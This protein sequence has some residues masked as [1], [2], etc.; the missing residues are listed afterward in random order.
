MSQRRRKPNSRS[1]D[2]SSFSYQRR[3]TDDPEYRNVVR[4]NA[5]NLIW[6]YVGAKTLARALQALPEKAT[7]WPKETEF[8]DRVAEFCEGSLKDDAAAVRPILENLL[9]DT[10]W[11]ARVYA[12]ECMIILYDD[13][14]ASLEP[15]KTDDTP[16]K[17]WLASGD[18]TIG[19]YVSSLDEQ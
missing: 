6:N 17:G 19:N 12:M 4:S 13:A 11:V 1:V 7:W 9:Y 15:L 14:V 10:N 2:R 3:R 16:L 18:T 8:R 5:L